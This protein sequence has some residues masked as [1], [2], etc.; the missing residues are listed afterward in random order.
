MSFSTTRALRVSM[1]VSNAKSF[2]F[3]SLSIG[4]VQVILLACVVQQT[5]Y[6]LQVNIF[7]VHALAE[8]SDQK[9]EVM[10]LNYRTRT[11]KA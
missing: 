5:S 9:R 8:K 4:P 2:V 3:N 11:L 1:N 10:L 6:M 7:W